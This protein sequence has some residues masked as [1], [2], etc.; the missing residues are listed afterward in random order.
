MS[1]NREELVQSLLNIGLNTLLNKPNS[2][3]STRPTSP[4]VPST[5][6]TPPTTD[7]YLPSKASQANLT[8][9][10]PPPPIYAPL[11]PTSPSPSVKSVKF[12]IKHEDIIKIQRKLDNL[13]NQFQFHE[14]T[15][16]QIQKTI[17]NNYKTTCKI[18]THHETNLENIHSCLCW[19]VPIM[20]CILMGIVA[21]VIYSVTK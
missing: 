10:A 1:E 19:F 12:D 3:P 14:D 18:H 9:N 13:S 2:N 16:R 21:L 8:P 20:I 4:F 7:Y 5:P 6:T 15:L 11:P 17:H